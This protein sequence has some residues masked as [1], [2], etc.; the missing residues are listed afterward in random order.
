MAPVGVEGGTGEERTAGAA[1]QT[2]MPLSVA[3]SV[4]RN[5]NFSGR[6]AASSAHGRIWA[7]GRVAG[8]EDY[9]ES[10]ASGVRGG[11]DV[12]SVVGGG[13]DGV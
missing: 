3:A 8:A 1:V 12:V 13:G 6:L 4:L 9:V 11:L 10:L 2:R 7:V 5:L